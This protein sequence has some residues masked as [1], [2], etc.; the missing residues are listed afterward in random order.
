MVLL[1]RW[2]GTWLRLRLRVWSLHRCRRTRLGLRGL[3]RG[4]WM[5]LRLRNLHRCRRTRLRLRG[6][7]RGRWMRLRL[8]DGDRSGRMHNRRTDRRRC[9]VRQRD[10]RARLR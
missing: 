6:L 10:I 9:V 4:G 7:H 1:R 2:F 3:H 5:R 8:R